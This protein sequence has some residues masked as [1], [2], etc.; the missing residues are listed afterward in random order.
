M[1]R[2]LDN[3]TSK[4]YVVLSIV[5]SNALFCAFYFRFNSA[6]CCV[7]YC[8]LLCFVRSAVDSNALCCALYCRKQYLVLYL[9]NN[10]LCCAIIYIL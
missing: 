5:N 4:L 1:A 8:R 9:D 10:A 7:I 3:K 2:T 6:F